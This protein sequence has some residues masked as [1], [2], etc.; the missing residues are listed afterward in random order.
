MTAQRELTA[1]AAIASA[2]EELEEPKAVARVLR[3]AADHFNQGLL[4]AGPDTGGGQDES[5]G[6]IHALFEAAAP[7]TD[8]ER[9]MLAGYWFQV[10]EGG[11]SFTGGQVNDSL[12]QMGVGAT[13]IAAVFSKLIA[14]KPALVQQVSKSGRS[15]QARKQYRL[16]TAG[17]SAARELLA[18]PAAEDA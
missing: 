18:R 15:Q 6:D 13:N 9:A 17:V 14:R 12:R 2:L 8:A 11:A 3:W 1:M 5:F 7:R 10:A 16:T 4:S